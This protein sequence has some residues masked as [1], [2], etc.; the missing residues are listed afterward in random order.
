MLS[1]RIIETASKMFTTF[2][3]KAVSMDDVAKSVGI[4][5]RTLYEMF[6]SKDEL[7]SQCMKL[8]REK[9]RE[10][11][12]AVVKDS[13]N[14]FVDI[15]IKILF[16]IKE[17]VRSANPVFYQDLQRFN[18][19]SASNEHERGREETCNQFMRLLER[20]VKEG[21][22]RKNIN[23]SLVAELFINQGATL[24]TTILHGKYATEEVLANLF[25]IHFRGI[26]TEKGIKRIDEVVEREG[27]NPLLKNN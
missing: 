24:K 14:D 8:H 7:L 26:S 13:S 20:G 25:L 1:N 18:F 17:D 3:L 10:K 15:V 4:S 9:G 22:I 12:E 16:I 23:L 19:R 6:S 2:G 5:K 11:F 21:Y 27:N